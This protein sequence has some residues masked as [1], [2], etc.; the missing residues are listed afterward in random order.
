[1][2]TP[3]V[4]GAAGLVWSLNPALKNT[5]VK[6]I[7]MDTVDKLSTLTGKCV[8]GGRINLKKAVEKAGIS[9]IDETPK[10][11]TV[12]TDT[13]SVITLTYSAV[14][15][16]IGDTTGFL[17][18]YNNDSSHNPLTVP[19][20][21]T[22]TQGIPKI[23][24]SET[25][26][27]LGEVFVH[28]TTKK[29]ITI[30][31]AGYTI[32]TVTNVAGSG[33]YTVDA[34]I[35]AYLERDASIEVMISFIPSATGPNNG[36]IS[37]QSNSPGEGNIS[38]ILT[39]TVVNPPHLVL[40][41]E[42]M[43][44]TVPNNGSGYSFMTIANPGTG[45]ASNLD[46]TVLTDIASTSNYQ[47]QRNGG[48]DDYGYRFLDSDESNGPI[49]SWSEITAIG[50]KISITGDDVNTG[51]FPIGFTFPFYGNNFTSF[52]VCSNGFISFTSSSTNYG[53][54]PLPSPD[55]PENLV[56]PFWN[57]FDM[58]TSG[59]IYY[60]SDG[61]KLVV[62]FIHIIPYGGGGDYSFQVILGNSGEIRFQYLNITGEN[63]FGTVG[64]QDAA[65]D[66]GLQVAYDDSYLKSNLAVRIVPPVQWLHVNPASGS[67][68]ANGFSIVTVTFNAL[69]MT[70]FDTTAYLWV[71]TNDPAH[72]HT[73]VPVTMHVTEN[74]IA[75][76]SADSISGISP[77][78]VQFTDNSYGSPTAWSWSF[79][80]GGTSILQNP[81]HTYTTDSVSYYDVTLNVI[82]AISADSMIRTAYITVYPNLQPLL[83]PLPDVK[84]LKGTTANG[85]FSLNDY[86]RVTTDWN[87]SS[88]DG[89]HQ[90]NIN[91]HPGMNTVD[92]QTTTNPDFTGKEKILFDMP[93]Y[94]SAGTTSWTK[95]SDYLISPLPYVV[96]D[97]GVVLKDGSIDLS[98]YVQPT[99]PS[100]WPTPVIRYHNALDDNRLSA[101]ITGNQL[102]I[103]VFGS[104]QDPAEIII[105]TNSTLTNYDSEIIRVYE[106][107]NSYAH[108]ANSTDT[109]QWAFQLAE[110]A[111]LLPS[112]AYYPEYNN[113]NGVLGVSFSSQSAGIK[114]TLGIP[115]WINSST[116]QWYTVRARVMCN[117]P[118]NKMNVQ[119]KLY[120]GTS[121]FMMSGRVL[122]GCPTT[123]KWF[124]T[125][126]YADVTSQLYPQFVVNNGG[127]SGIVYLDEV[128]VI[129]AKPAIKL[130]YGNTRQKNPTADFDI[131]SDST[132]WAFEDTE[133]TTPG[134]Y[135][136]S[137]GNLNI[138][139]AEL[140][141]SG[142]KITGK[143]AE[144]STLTLAV[145]ANRAAGMKVNYQFSRDPSNAILVLKIFGTSSTYGTTIEEIAGTAAIQHLPSSGILEATMLPDKPY[146]YGQLVAKSLIFADYQFDDMYLQLDEANPYLWDSSLF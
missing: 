58:S 57:D 101:L 113:A 82:N 145:P 128:Q 99:V 24:L 120:N 87:W 90:V 129:A 18:I 48:P 96:V 111:S 50:T 79:G 117:I 81:Q 133:N 70:N 135:D 106:V 140:P 98:N 92:Y 44:N 88:A 78:S 65:K 19:I 36:N 71:N 15:M 123:W 122:Y 56:A 47:I 126:I 7:L 121:T 62:S 138:H 64:I 125:S 132:G 119:L 12:I 76:F 112:I 131:A 97:N 67:T 42:Q 39:A 53:N 73:S 28:S 127:E 63:R 3:H 110:T 102:N 146:I 35:P 95:Y 134:T 114:M 68:P 142:M 100:S 59:S 108:F 33:E 37:I 34:P 55:A 136:I 66:A 60:Y 139:F 104:L 23:S 93:A 116:G 41:P 10:S 20:S 16:P 54:T 109:E 91:I 1:M 89:Q 13:Y 80:D 27:A 25:T 17:V 124:E 69:G 6:Q 107:L 8:T 105:S 40:V 43:T 38:V 130:A 85:V 21:M 84:L 32:L 83:Q 86:A 30:K 94:G 9:W 118:N 72:L 115:N 141:P 46:W 11:G 22:V 52:R 29:T 26:V 4:S 144:G 61:S 49:F 137:H 143:Y 2:A 31:N 75:D 14:N 103:N 45:Y 51:T 5:D 77:L 74:L